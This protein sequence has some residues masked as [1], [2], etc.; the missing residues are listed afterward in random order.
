MLVVPFVLLVVAILILAGVVAAAMGRGGELT[1][2]YRDLPEQRFLLR[3]AAD[4]AMLRLPTRLF[5][6]QEQATSGALRAITDLLARQEAEIASLRDE[7]WRL[8]APMNVG[9]VP[10]EIGP[11]PVEP[12][13]AADR[14]GAPD[15]PQPPL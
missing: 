9:S 7:V 3:S 4:V 8:S 6:Y 10:A 2:F 12:G 14:D 15:Q 1:L 13:G 11:A 5:G